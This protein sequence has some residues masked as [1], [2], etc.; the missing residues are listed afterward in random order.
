M[1]GTAVDEPTQMQS[2]ATV[3]PPRL[4]VAEDRRGAGEDFAARPTAISVRRND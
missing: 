4:E 3:I 2:S 1:V